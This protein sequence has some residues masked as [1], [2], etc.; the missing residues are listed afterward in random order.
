MGGGGGAADW[1]EFGCREVDR[2]EDSPSAMVKSKC[3]QSVDE[4]VDIRSRASDFFRLLFKA[5]NHFGGGGVGDLEVADDEG[6]VESFKH[7]GDGFFGGSEVR[8]G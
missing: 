3:M 7:R 5:D 1:L 2:F 4:V 6:E 8:I